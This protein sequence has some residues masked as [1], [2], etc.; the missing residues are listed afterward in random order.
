MHACVSSCD[1][2][3]QV[4][5]DKDVAVHS[6]NWD[7]LQIQRLSS[8]ID[9]VHKASNTVAHVMVTYHHGKNMIKAVRKA[10]T[11]AIEAEQDKEVVDSKASE[12]NRLLSGGAQA[13]QM[14][15]LLQE[16]DSYSLGKPWLEEKLKS[17]DFI[18]RSKDW[19]F[20]SWTEAF[21]K[22]VIEAGR[23]TS[24]TDC[25]YH[26]Q[27]FVLKEDSSQQC[28]LFGRLAAL[29]ALPDDD[30][31]KALALEAASLTMQIKEMAHT[32]PLLCTK[33]K[34]LDLYARVQALQTA[35]LCKA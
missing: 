33:E 32:D 31:C 35:E 34:A 13:C 8:S 27:A 9:E 19:A 25:Q 2:A 16:V 17:H 11:S 26:V 10:Q 29:K 3:F 30:C 20:K 15:K 24:V 6:R 22:C 1:L 23:A 21:S 14:V 12:L 7:K 5:V 18:K 28:I 4:A